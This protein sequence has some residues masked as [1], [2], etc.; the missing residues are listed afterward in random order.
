M[1][2]WTNWKDS[3]EDNSSSKL[4]HSQGWK[5]AACLKALL[6]ESSLR[7]RGRGWEAGVRLEFL[8]GVNLR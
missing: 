1:E 7:Q 2:N 6:C 4:A 5:L 3:P 8:L